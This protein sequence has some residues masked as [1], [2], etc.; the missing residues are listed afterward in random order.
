MFKFGFMII[1]LSSLLFSKSVAGVG[2]NTSSYVIIAFWMLLNG[3]IFI[4]LSW[5]RPDKKIDEDSILSKV[6]TFLINVTGISL[7]G[8]I[9][10][11]IINIYTDKDSS[12]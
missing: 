6:M 12:I 10:K 5:V 11:Y 9:I 3:I 8:L 2:T 7:I 1:V 4:L